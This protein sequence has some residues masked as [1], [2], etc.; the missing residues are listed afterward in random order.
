MYKFLYGVLVVFAVSEFS[1]AQSSTCDSP[2]A[3]QFDFWIGRWKLTWKNSDGD[4]VQGRNEIAALYDGCVIREQFE[5]PTSFRGTSLSVYSPDK[6]KWQQTWVDNAGAY[7]DFEGEFRD[8]VMVLGRNASKNGKHFL[9]RMRWY[10]IERNS[11]DWNWER[12]DDNGHTWKVLWS[13]HY[14]RTQPTE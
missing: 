1:L 3:R 10:N 13:I 5:S 4:I 9:Q 12:S 14:E 7:L 2:E 6:H 8:S 11:L